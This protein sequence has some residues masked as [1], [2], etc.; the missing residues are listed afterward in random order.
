MPTQILRTGCAAISWHDSARDHVPY[1]L[2]DAHDVQLS[3]DLSHDVLRLFCG[4]LK[5]GRRSPC[6]T[7]RRRPAKGLRVLGCQ[8]PIRSCTVLCSWVS[9]RCRA[10]MRGSLDCFKQNRVVEGLL[11]EFRWFRAAT[12]AG[13]LAYPLSTMTGISS[14]RRRSSRCKSKPLIPGSLTSTTRQPGLCVSLFEIRTTSERPQALV[15]RRRWIAAVP[16]ARR[17]T[18]DAGNFW[19]AFGT[20]SSASLFMCCRSD[21]KASAINCR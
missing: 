5:A 7:F 1:Q 4:S 8:A 2:C 19:A 13:T 11:Q 3:H 6:S 20:L 18:A 16:A 10:R 17:S 14:P 9:A 21:A 12:T 15:F